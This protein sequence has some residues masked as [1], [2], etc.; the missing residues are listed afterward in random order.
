MNRE[1]FAALLILGS[2]LFLSLPTLAQSTPPRSVRVVLDNNYPPFVFIQANGQLAGILVDEWGLW[3]RQTGIKAELH[4]MDWG[5][6]LRRMQ[7][8]EFDVIDTIFETHDRTNYLDFSKPYARLDVPIFFRKDLAGI[9]SL[10]SLKGFPVAAKTGDA[11]VELLKQ[12]GFDTVLLFTN[13]EA[14][15]EAARERRV[16]VFIMDRP[17][18]LYFLNKL[19]IQNE[20][21]QSAPVN[22]GEFHRA[23]RKGNSALLK[24]VEQGFAALP[25]AE[26][27]QIQEKWYGRPLG[28]WPNLRYIG[29]IA[30][31]GLL[32]IL[33]LGVWNLSLNRLVRARTAALQESESRLRAILD[34]IPDWVWLKDTNSRYVT[35]NVPY[36][37][38]V[39]STIQTLP[40]RRDA[41]LWPESYAKK[42]VADDQAVM[43]S[44]QPKRLIEEVTDPQGQHRIVETLKAPVRN[45]V[46][47]TIGAVGI[48]RD[49][50]ERMRA[51]ANLRRLNRT[52]RMLSQC[53]ETVVRATDEE[54]LLKAICRLAV[55]AGGY[56]MAWVGFAENDA[57]RSVR[58]VARAG[59]ESGY[60]E[61]VK[62]TWGDTERGHGPMGTAIRLGQPVVTR[63]T[64]T[65][66][67][68]SPWREAAVQRGYC[69]CAAFPLKRGSSMLGALMV[70]AAEPDTFDSEEVTLLSELAE[71]LAYGITALRIR[72]EHQRTEEALNA[73]EK[74]FRSIFENAPIGIFQSTPSGRLL[75]V[76]LAGAR[77]FGFDSP[78]SLLTATADVSQQLFV[79]PE[80]GGDIVQEALQ[81]NTFIRRE[82]EYRRKD[83]SVFIAHLYMRVVRE[84]GE[85]AAMVEGFVED[86]TERKRAEEGLLQSRERARALSARLQSLREE[87]RTR[88]AREI[89]DH[90]GQLLTALKLDL[91]AMDRKLPLM[92][93]GE[94][95]NAMSAKITSGLELTG[96]VITSVQKIAS[97]LRPGVLDRLG[98]TAAL[99]TELEAFQMRTG[100]ACHWRLPTEPLN[101]TQDQASAM[102]RIFQ[103]ILTNIARH[104]QATELT[105]QLSVLEGELVLEAN[106]NGVGIRQNDI[107]RPSSLGILGMQ[108]RA[109]ILGGRVTFSQGPGAGTTVRV[110]VPL[111][112]TTEYHH[113]A[114]SHSG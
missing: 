21:N 114:D 68:F 13:Y 42:F 102:F 14:I 87:E 9:S 96:E 54:E 99:E 37:E 74:K 27:N 31:S 70:Y 20:F 71:D 46:G 101:L 18:A 15:V 92:P 51:D 2:L 104:A 69:G 100:I 34:H 63:N 19:G 84:S 26:L 89:H 79:S 81:C 57:G 11:A 45:T 29:Y 98:L 75:S 109:A 82:V 61:T 3:E 52:L 60:L 7:A 73:S 6:A 77:M 97:E 48:A 49:I 41:E 36:V 40:G 88:L 91:H 62:V 90:L 28:N 65:D 112:R 50:T 12:K 53:N 106:D 72:V 76:N 35:A 95:R 56:R 105:V 59:Y 111:E 94:L 47:V 32:L 107:D 113:E 10:E 8:G 85:G 93:E 44:G 64:L 58:P 4:G 108:E 83:S 38:A 43:Q 25:P 5:E 39:K 86:I 17:P 22:T 103:E 24:T 110:N 1:C 67:A 78:A 23:V 55:E 16:N 30:V 80:Q 66:P 33:G